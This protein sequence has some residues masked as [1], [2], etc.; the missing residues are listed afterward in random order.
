MVVPATEIEI[1]PAQLH[2]HL[3]ELFNAGILRIVTVGD[4]GVHGVVTGIQGVGVST[5]LAAAVADAVVG[6]AKDEHIPNVGM[7]VIGTKSI[8]LAAGFLSAVTVGTVTINVAGAAPKLQDMVADIATSCA[9]INYLSIYQLLHISS[10]SKFG[11]SHNLT[12]G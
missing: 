9:M 7:L 5:P 10:L 4:P 8:I 2:M 1:E 11:N 3:D 6:F 12:G